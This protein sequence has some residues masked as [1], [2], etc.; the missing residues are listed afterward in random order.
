MISITHA[1]EFAKETFGRA[2]LGD[3]RRTQRLLD[4][5]AAAASRPCASIPAACENDR[6][7]VQ[8]FYKLIR[9]EDVAPEAIRDAA[10]GSSARVVNEDRDDVVLIH[11]TTSISP[12]H[13]LCEQLRSKAG[14]PAGYEVHTGLLVGAHSGVP[15]GILGQLIWSRAVP[16]S[17]RLLDE[18]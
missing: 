5:A 17:K 13:A 2:K 9:N 11:D 16:K 6:A 7:R 14:S 3:L 10:F 18:G 1:R 8:G 12:T 15:L 4:A